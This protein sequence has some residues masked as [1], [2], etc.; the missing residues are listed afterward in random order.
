MVKS[1]R[2]TLSNGVTVPAIGFGTYLLDNAQAA[3]CVLD[4]IQDGYRLI[5]G[6]SFYHNETGVGQ[7]LCQAMDEGA[8]REDL[9]VTSKVWKDAMGYEQTLESFEKS[10]ADLGLEYLDLYL[11]HWPFGDPELDRSTWQALIDLYKAGRVRAIGVSNFMPENLLPLFD[12]EIVPMVNQIMVHPGWKQETVTD[13]CRQH[14]IQV[15]A[16]S[17]LGR[18]RVLNNHL[19]R[20]LAQE[21]G[22]SPAQICL[23]WEIQKGF[24][25]I[26]KSANAARIRENLD[27]FDFELTPDQMQALD[28]LP[29]ME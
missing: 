27:V 3:S 4:A 5:D 18:G 7:G 20:Q 11:I 14:G 9:F 2:K 12:M 13:F 22:K 10:L 25:P 8:K 21:H 15:M 6:A 26:P 1:E 24:I 29:P 23:R 17:P 19:L 16:W 28:S